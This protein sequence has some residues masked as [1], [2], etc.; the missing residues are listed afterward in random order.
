MWQKV[1]TVMVTTAAKLVRSEDFYVTEMADMNNHKYLVLNLT[2]CRTPWKFQIHN[3][4]HAH[5][6]PQ[7]TNQAKNPKKT[8]K[9][10]P[11]T[12]N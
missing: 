8:N 7:K 11:T 3:F 5:N 9:K 4:L 2:H 10:A 6:K 1:D 12:N